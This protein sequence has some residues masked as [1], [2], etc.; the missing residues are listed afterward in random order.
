MTVRPA[1]AAWGIGGALAFATIIAI[2][3]PAKPLL[4]PA[5]EAADADATAASCSQAHVQAVVTSATDVNEDD[6]IVVDVPA[7]NCTWE[8][9]WPGYYV[10]WTNKN[11]TLRGAGIGETVISCGISDVGPTG[12][13]CVRWLNTTDTNDYSQSR[14][15][16]FTFS[17]ALYGGSAI[18][19]I[20]NATTT[21]PH[22]GWRIDHNRFIYAHNM[23]CFNDEVADDCT[24]GTAISAQGPTYGVI[25]HNTFDWAHQGFILGVTSGAA[26]ENTE[27]NPSGEIMWSQPA[28]LGTANFIFIEDNDINN[29]SAT[30]QS[31]VVMDTAGGGGRVVIRYN[32]IQSGFFNH[33]WVRGLDWCGVLLEVYRNVF[34]G[35]TDQGSNSPGALESG[36]G[37]IWENQVT[38][39]DNPFA[40]TE[41]R[42]GGTESTGYFEGCD[43]TQLWDGNAGDASAP[44]WPCLGQVGRGPGYT[45]D[46]IVAGQK[47]PSL[48]LYLWKNGV[49]ST[50][51]T[52]G[53]CTDSIGLAVSPDADYLKAT[54]HS[55]V[56]E[57]FGHG[58]VDYILGGQTAKPGYT[59][60]T[61]PHPLTLVP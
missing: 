58:E 57:G 2:G 11:I 10:T 60:Y 16:G 51:A 55:V 36:T 26:T 6:V 20:D 23:T 45:F 46:Q 1:H 44:G 50:C 22:S 37:V 28:D 7:G 39:Y 38:G 18:V 17:I 5:A 52:G 4:G 9:A 15:T 47:Q 14:V 3:G 33:H 59:P 30:D 19:I 34:D 27:A 41:R 48:P 56:G 21:T 54:A 35:D 49:E 40:A 29:L 13:N 32:N 42:G 43:G 53:A 31:V 12:G 8:G 25:D 61:Y 24:S